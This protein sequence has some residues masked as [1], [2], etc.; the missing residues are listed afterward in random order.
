MSFKFQYKIKPKNLWVLTMFNIYRT[1]MAVINVIFTAS[2]V[3]LSVKFFGN[4]LFFV[5]GLLIFGIMIFPVFQ[6]FLIYLRCKKIVARMPEDME[7]LIDKTGITTT[8]EGQTSHVNYSDVKSVLI[9]RKLLVIYTK[10]KH[11]FILNEEVIG[12]QKKEV[13]NFLKAK[14]K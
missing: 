4:S 13:F 6:P 7:M 3:L 1:M 8:S 11:S 14:V 2:M 10:T 5:K 9:V 12:S